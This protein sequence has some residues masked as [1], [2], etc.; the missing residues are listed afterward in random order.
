MWHA[1]RTLREGGTTALDVGCGSAVLDHLARAQPDHRTRK[2]LKS[3][4][5]A[6]CRASLPE[7]YALKVGEAPAPVTRPK[8]VLLTRMHPRA[9]LRVR[10]RRTTSAFL[11]RGGN[12]ATTHLP[13]IHGNSRHRSRNR[14]LCP[15]WIIRRHRHS[16]HLESA[17]SVA[18][19]EYVHEGAVSRLPG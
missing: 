9:I 2:K 19:D 14:M 10:T 15:T 16:F 3:S 17:G 8:Q 6:S 1:K 11:A 12:Y 4:R 18:K 7:G 5:P 13:R